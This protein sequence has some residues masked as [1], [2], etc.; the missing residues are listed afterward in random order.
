MFRAGTSPVWLE[1]YQALNREMRGPQQFL[2][3]YAQLI[4]HPMFCDSDGDDRGYHFSNPD[5]RHFCL[6]KASKS[7]VSWKSA[8]VIAKAGFH[9]EVISLLRVAVEAATLTKWAASS[10][11][12]N[13][14]RQYLDRVQKVVSGY[15]EDYERTPTELPAPLKI[16]ITDVHKMLSGLMTS[17][18]DVRL[19]LNGVDPRA[20]QTSVYVRFSKYVHAG[21]PETIDL[22]GSRVG[23]L[24]L[25]GSAGS[26]IKD[27][28]S[29]EAVETIFDTVRLGIA[30]IPMLLDRGSIQ[31]LSNEATEWLNRFR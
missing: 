19:A 10:S 17:D 9:T 15:F 28:E 22:F 29:Y 1:K 13:A 14:S 25:D 4:G 8:Q 23:E 31:K 24:G 3:E 21:Y 6:L 30:L 12:A 5:I 26:M 20:L 16:S 27:R 7:I 2:I 18:G 11:S